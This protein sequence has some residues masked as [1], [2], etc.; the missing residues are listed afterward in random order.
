MN[1][2]VTSVTSLQSPLLCIHAQTD[3]KDLQPDVNVGVPDLTPSIIRIH[4][5]CR[6]RRWIN[7][8][9]SVQRETGC[10]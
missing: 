4:V 9:F 8:H 1:V 7:F 2:W 3:M 6:L 5:T 10:S